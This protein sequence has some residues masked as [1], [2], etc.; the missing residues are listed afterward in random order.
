MN[1]VMLCRHRRNRRRFL[2]AVWI[3]LLLTHFAVFAAGSLRGYDFG[4]ENALG[5]VG[6][7]I[8]KNHEEKAGINRNV[9]DQSTMPA[10]RSRSF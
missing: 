10:S 3:M 8:Q 1:R 2:A 7:Q 5:M 9:R 6:Q 4:F